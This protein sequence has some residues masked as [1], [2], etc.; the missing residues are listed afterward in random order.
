[1]IIVI[2]WIIF[3][4]F[5]FICLIYGERKRYGLFEVYVF[6]IIDFNY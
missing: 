5:V 3:Y 1:M 4:D 2:N 6:R